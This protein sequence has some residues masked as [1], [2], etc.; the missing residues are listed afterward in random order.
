MYFMLDCIEN[1]KFVKFIVMFVR[2][3]FV[4]RKHSSEISIALLLYTNL[5]AN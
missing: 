1:V 4:N 2:Y 5:H 3:D